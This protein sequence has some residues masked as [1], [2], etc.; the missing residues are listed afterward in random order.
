MTVI[1]PDLESFRKPVLATV[2]SMFEDKW[3]KGHFGQ[4]AGDLKLIAL[5]GAC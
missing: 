2:P 4:A 5:A 3:G 1:E